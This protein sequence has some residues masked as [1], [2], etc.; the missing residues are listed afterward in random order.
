MAAALYFAGAVVL[1]LLGVVTADEERK[2]RD[3]KKALEADAVRL[4][5]ERTRLRLRT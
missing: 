3:K 4:R 2:Q 5:A 1:G